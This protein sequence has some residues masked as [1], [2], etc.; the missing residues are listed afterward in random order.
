MSKISNFIG[1][2]WYQ[3]LKPVFDKHWDKI[4]Q[5]IKN[6][7]LPITPDLK[8]VF[9][10]YKECSPNTLHTIVLGVDPY[11]GLIY[12]KKIADGIAFS[13]IN[14]EGN[15][16]ESLKQMW[17]A[18]NDIQHQWPTTT[19]LKYLSNQGILL[20][21]SYLT[22]TI[23]TKMAHK[24]I[25]TEFTIDCIKEITKRFSGLNIVF[26]GKEAQDFSK[27]VNESLHFIYKLSHPDIM[28]Y[29]KGIWEYDDVFTKI[30]KQLINK[31]LPSINWGNIIE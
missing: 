9:R 12:N 1:E 27:Y 25:W 8:D 5:S 3:I 22:T 7:K 4:S 14:S 15:P 29:K 30:N 23:G 21:N 10:A 11:S 6:E 26:I 16:P 31:N 24:D 18:W 17:H 13:S 20:L 28:I 2:E 19:N